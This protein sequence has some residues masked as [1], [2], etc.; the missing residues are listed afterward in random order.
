MS[1]SSPRVMFEKNIVDIVAS[2]PHHD[3]LGKGN[4]VNVDG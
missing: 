1:E 2:S 3:A 4:S